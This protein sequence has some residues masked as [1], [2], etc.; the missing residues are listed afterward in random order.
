MSSII[1]DGLNHALY[2]QSRIMKLT[3]DG[4]FENVPADEL[5]LI[6]DAINTSRES[7]AV[8]EEAARSALRGKLS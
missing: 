1:L 8:L 7:L 5:L 3:P 4:N 6:I 2:A